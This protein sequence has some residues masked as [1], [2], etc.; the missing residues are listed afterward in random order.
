MKAHIVRMHDIIALAKTIFAGTHSIEALRAEFEMPD[1]EF[2]DL[3]SVL[4][5]QL[6]AFEGFKVLPTPAVCKYLATGDELSTETIDS[7]E[8]ALERDYNIQAPWFITSVRGPGGKS[9]EYFYLLC[10]RK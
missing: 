6:A 1:N 5:D 2:A 9:L 3:S 10:E 7:M 8:I 4:P